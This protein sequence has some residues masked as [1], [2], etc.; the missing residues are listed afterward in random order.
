MLAACRAAEGVQILEE[1]GG[2]PDEGELWV[3]LEAGW[4]DG[5]LAGLSE[6][7][8][9]F[10]PGV[11][12]QQP[13]L[14]EASPDSQ[15]RAGGLELFAADLSALP[16]TTWAG[17]GLPRGGPIRMLAGSGDAVRPV[18][19]VL[20]ELVYL[21]ETHATGLLLFDDADLGLWPGWL[22]ALRAECRHL[23]WPLSWQGTIS[24][25]RASWE[26]GPLS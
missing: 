25:A 16:I 13:R 10:G 5:R 20:R 24:G 26:T 22:E 12:G 6:P 18:A 9:F 8:I 11:D 2:A 21:V 17:F 7:A 3:H 14:R 15:T 1:L 19:H 23:P 4:G